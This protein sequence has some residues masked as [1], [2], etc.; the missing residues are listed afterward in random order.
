[1]VET[2]SSRHCNRSLRKPS[3][4]GFIEQALLD[5]LEMLGALGRATFADPDAI[6]LIHAIDG[7][8]AVS[9]WQREDLQRHPF[10]RVA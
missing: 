4:S 2:L 5:E 3:N 6:L 10:L 1:M 7:R 8:S 9:L